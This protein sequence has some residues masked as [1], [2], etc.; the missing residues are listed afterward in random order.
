VR[1]RLA[2]KRGHERSLVSEGRGLSHRASRDVPAAA[3]PQVPI[4]VDADEQRDT[5][6]LG[7]PG[8]LR[9]PAASVRTSTSR[10]GPTRTE[11]SPAARTLGR[12]CSTAVVSIAVRA[13]DANA[14]ARPG[15]AGAPNSEAMRRKPS[16]VPQPEQTFGQRSREREGF[17]YPDPGQAAATGY[18]WVHADRIVAPIQ[19]LVETRHQGWSGEGACRCGRLALGL[20]LSQVR[21]DSE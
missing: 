16:T 12:A 6:R 14:P 15:G 7:S 13:S 8:C 4:R 19:P 1:W 11:K 17:L 3:F 10:S 2:R 20:M 18:S 9:K 5:P 21:G